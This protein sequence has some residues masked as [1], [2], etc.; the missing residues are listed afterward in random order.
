MREDKDRTG[1]WL[2]AHFGDSILKLAGIV[3]FESWSPV[4]S[5]TV[6]LKR[7]P[8]GLMEL[9]YPGRNKPDLVLVEIETYPGSDAD[10]QMLE[11]LEIVHLTRGIV[12]DSVMIVLSPKGNQTVAG[13]TTFAS[14]NGATRLAGQWP[15][16][17]LWELNAADLLATGDPGLVP[18]VPLAQTSGAPSALLGECKAILDA[19]PDRSTRESL[20]VATE[21]MAGLAYPQIRFLELFGGPEM[22]IESPVL[23]EARKLW[24]RRNEA[25]ITAKVTA[26]VSAKIAAEIQAKVAAEIQAKVAAE[27][28]ARL[29]AEVNL[30][31]RAR[32]A[33]LTVLEARFGSLPAELRS[34]LDS[35]TELTRLD[36]MIPVAATAPDL[37]SFS[38]A[39]ATM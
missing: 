7:L 21:I 1:K 35:E 9:K 25:R 5:E 13:T 11:D 36:A 4:Q 19:I 39:L 34:T 3:G 31:A 2:I 17:R 10:R 8:D 32:K 16:V 38:A 37:D 27:I 22:M 33:V 18:W 26:E 30:Q 15:V 28:E 23:E 6:A 24:D 20:L 14:R 29:T 12:P